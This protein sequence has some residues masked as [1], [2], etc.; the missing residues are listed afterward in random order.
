M[1]PASAVPTGL[2]ASGDRF[3]RRLAEQRYDWDAIGR[4]FTALVEEM[5]Q[6]RR[7]LSRN[8]S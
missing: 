8:L 3:T 7:A 4:R 1:T 2:T 6:T 5:V